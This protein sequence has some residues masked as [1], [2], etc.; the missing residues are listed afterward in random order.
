[1]ETMTMKVETISKE[2]IKPS[3]P[4]PNNLQTLQLSIYDHILPPVYTVAFLFYTKNDLISQEHTSHKLKTSLSETLTKF[5]PLAGRITGVT[6]D[7]TDEGAIFV[8]ARVNNCP[9]TEFLKC[10]DFDALQQLL[11]LDVVD[12]P[13]VAAAT[14]PLLLVKAT[15]F[16]CGGMAIGI[17]IT[18]KIAD[19]ASI[20]TFIRSWAATARGEN[21]A[22]AMESPVFA[23]ANFYP[24]A[25]E[26]FKLPADEQAGKRSSIT[27]RFV[28]E[29]SKVE[30]LRTKAASEETVDQPTRVESVT[31][32]IWKCF[33]ASSK[34][35]TCDHKVLVQLANL[36]SKIPSLL[37]ESSIGNLMFSS[38]VLSIGRGGEVKIEEAVRDLRKKK[39][40]LGTV[41]LDE[42][43]SSDS[44]SMIGSKLANLMLTNYSRLSYETHEPYTVSSWCKLPLYEASFGWDSPVWVVGNVSPV[45]GN[46]AMLIDSKDGQ[47]IEAFVTL[48]EEN[49]SS[50]EQNPELLAF[51]TMNPSVLV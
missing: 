15:Y 37:Q 14:W 10:P 18:H 40:E 24:P 45:L 8:D 46:L 4:T 16:G 7:C 42:G 22:A 13:Y 6:V 47:G 23:G 44:S 38:V 50:F 11:P 25:N 43:G 1:M 28:F 51:A 21:D 33:V 32:L 3:S 30:D 39:E 9:L 36:R 20:S 12:N 35:T 17:C 5:Y 34:T 29:A 2:I 48:P 49:M 27:K 31:A 26:A 41:I 19:A